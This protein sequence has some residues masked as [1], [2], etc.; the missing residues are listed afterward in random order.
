MLL[1]LPAG[2]LNCMERAVRRVTIQSPGGLLQAQD[3]ES[4]SVAAVSVKLPPY[5]PNDPC[6]WFIQAESMFR[7]RGITSQETKFDHVVSSL[8]PEF[9][10]E[11]RDLLTN[12]P[13]DAPY[14]KLKTEL[15]KRTQ[16]SEQ[17]R[18]RQLLTEEEL[19]DKT[20][21]QL[22]RRL[23][24]LLGD[25]TMDTSFLRELFVQRLPANVQ[26]VLASAPESLT[27]EALA[28][29]ADRVL[30]VSR[31]TPPSV[32]ALESDSAGAIARLELQVSALT[33]AFHEFRA[34]PSKRGR[35]P[36]PNRADR[37][38]SPSG[39]R[40]GLPVSSGP[41]STQSADVSELCFYHRKFGTKALK[42]VAPCAYLQGN[43]PASH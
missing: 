43:A 10:A 25:T 27:L 8:A 35:S 1:A 17:R 42:C 37:S 21:S 3:D 18:L 38:R 15:I 36:W 11:V 24:Q 13:S 4:T 12:R 23:R 16:S 31:P 14:D 9:A 5:W 41:Q 26:M 34:Q 28:E 7:I 33:A 6:I 29:M 32:H 22:L 2:V 19:G 39:S 30:E 40:D 20:P